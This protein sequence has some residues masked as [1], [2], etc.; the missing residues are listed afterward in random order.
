MKN[1]IIYNTVDGKASVSLYARDGMVWMNQNQIAELFD[2]SVPNISMHISNIL[3]EEE[4][5]A[6]SVI[7]DYLTTA[8]D[9]KQ[10]KVTFYTLDMVLAIGFRVRSKR[11]TQFRIWANRNLK[12]YMVKGFVM[13]DERLKNPDGRPDYFDELLER[14]RDIRASEKRFYQK[15]RDL[16]ALSSDYD[17][18]D[19]ATQMFFAETQSKLLYAVT[20]K[21]AAEIPVSRADASKQNMAL[22]SWKGSIVRKQ[23]IFIAKNYLSKDEIDT[24][25]RLVVIFLET[26]ELRAKERMDIPMSFWKEN[27]DRILAFHDK[28]VLTG[29]GTISNDEAEKT[30]ITNGCTGFL[31][32]CAQ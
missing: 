4:L 18:T 28:K 11:G 29:K 14:I 25:N 24:L 13:D 30:G 3:K 9:G 6:N 16:F 15:L 23:D 26:A 12:G 10:Y 20:G 31:L 17:P 32:R 22:T 7:K 2:T 21:T 19:K 27:V 1:I 5:D 8:A